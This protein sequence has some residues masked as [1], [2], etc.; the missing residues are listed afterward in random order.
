[1]K[2]SRKDVIDSTPAISLLLAFITVAWGWYQIG[3]IVAAD[4][5]QTKLELVL[6]LDALESYCV[7]SLTNDFKTEIS[8][9]KDF[10]RTLRKMWE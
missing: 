6:K 2:K 9:D 5:K 4:E 7:R 1:M 10:C 3:K 8:S